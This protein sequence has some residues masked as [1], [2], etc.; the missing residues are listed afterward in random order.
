M[1]K[2]IDEIKLNIKLIDI[3]CVVLDS[4][5]PD[6]SKND[7]IFDIAK[8]K[9]IIVIFNKC[10]L[11]DPDRLNEKVSEYEDKGYKVVLTNAKVQ[12]I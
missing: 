12:N 11:A 7:I 9:P 8:S 6:S 5:I 1:K 3:V 10:D 2:T 4:R